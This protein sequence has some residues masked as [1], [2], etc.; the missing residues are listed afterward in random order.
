M[1]APTARTVSWVCPIRGVYHNSQVHIKVGRL[2]VDAHA[3]CIAW[4]LCMGATADATLF[5]E[6]VGRVSV[7]LELP[8]PQ[9]LQVVS[10]G[11]AS[12]DDKHARLFSLIRQAPR[13]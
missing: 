6:T 3:T 10:T 13:T 8:T 5:L 4:K 1:F 2:S 7:Y 11:K 9:L 12:Q